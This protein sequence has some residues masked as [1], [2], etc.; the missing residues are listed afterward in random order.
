MSKL[1]LSI[2]DILE[3]IPISKSTWWEGVRTGRF[4]KPLRISVRRTVW[5]KA[6]IDRFLETGCEEWVAKKVVRKND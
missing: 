4:P 6:D 1:F 2:K 5:R 3:I